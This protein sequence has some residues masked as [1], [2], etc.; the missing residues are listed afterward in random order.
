MVS[1]NVSN[2]IHTEI[3]TDVCISPE[4][5]PQPLTDSFPLS[6][7]RLGKANI[8]YSDENTLCVR[9]KEKMV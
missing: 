8:V 2:K 5:V 4:L 3:Y 7:I 9:L 6:K 1:T